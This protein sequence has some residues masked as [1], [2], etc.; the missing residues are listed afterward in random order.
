[1]YNNN[2]YTCNT[3]SSTNNTIPNLKPTIKCD[4]CPIHIILV[5][6]RP[7]SHLIPKIIICTKIVWLGVSERFTKQ[8]NKACWWVSH[9]AL[10]L[11]SQ[12]R[13]VNDSIYN[14]DWVFLEI[15]VKSRIVGYSLTCPIDPSHHWCCKS[16]VCNLLLLKIAS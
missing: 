4:A 1:M 13:P 8:V 16:Q 5:I 6:L 15:P 7:F 14:F 3:Q 10:F 2:H 11:K 12:T 9:N